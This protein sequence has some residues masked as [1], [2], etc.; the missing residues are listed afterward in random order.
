MNNNSSDDEKHSSPD[1]NEKKRKEYPQSVDPKMVENRRN[2]QIPN[3]PWEDDPERFKVDCHLLDN[4][5]VINRKKISK[6]QQSMGMRVAL[7][8]MWII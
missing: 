4:F 6:N 7:E 5:L 3:K 1:E 2:E 8:Y